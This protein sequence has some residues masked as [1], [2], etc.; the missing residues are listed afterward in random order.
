MHRKISV[1]TLNR[2]YKELRNMNNENTEKQD[3]GLSEVDER[4]AELKEQETN[5]LEFLSKLNHTEKR[6][7][8][9]K[10]FYEFE[11][12]TLKLANVIS[13]GNSVRLN[14]NGQSLDVVSLHQFDFLARTL[15]DYKFQFPD[16]FIVNSDVGDLDLTIKSPR[17]I[18][19]VTVGTDDWEPDTEDLD[20]V[21]KLFTE[22][23]DDSHG[24]IVASRT[25]LVV[26]D[27]PEYC[28]VD[29]VAKDDYA[30]DDNDEETKLI[31]AQ[32]ETIDDLQ[33]LSTLVGLFERLA[34]TNC[35]ATVVVR[36][37]TFTVTGRATADRMVD[38]LE[39]RIKEL[40][41]DDVPVSVDNTEGKFQFTLDCSALER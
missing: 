5:V 26:H 9:Y 12:L 40:R 38:L 39:Y 14:V 19:H 37:I 22:A 13:G 33:I 20:N 36:D 24:A 28:T 7:L 2:K 23:N 34:T 6:D 21:I 15:R 1:Q 31:E 10:S 8:F 3:V 4:M 41:P 25:G 16:M 30:Y 18:L 29:A 35:G 27:L 32:L 17:G 11:E